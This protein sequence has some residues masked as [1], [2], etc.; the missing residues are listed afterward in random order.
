MRVAMRQRLYHYSTPI[1][2]KLVLLSGL[3]LHL[4]LSCLFL[5]LVLL[6]DFAKEF[7]FLLIRLIVICVGLPRLYIE[8]CGLC[9]Y[10]LIAV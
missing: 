8:L 9:E 2:I 4:G 3:L 1:N 10:G 7:V 6:M 5:L